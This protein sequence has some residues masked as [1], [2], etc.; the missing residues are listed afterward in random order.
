MFRQALSCWIVALALSPFTAPF[1]TCD[2]STLLATL[3]AKHAEAEHEPQLTHVDADAAITVAS[4][5]ALPHSSE[6][7][8]TGRARFVVGL[9]SASLAIPCLLFEAAVQGPLGVHLKPFRAPNCDLVGTL[10]I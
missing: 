4:R 7:P 8:V 2:F 5:L 1:C 6:P 9:P 3:S 10:R